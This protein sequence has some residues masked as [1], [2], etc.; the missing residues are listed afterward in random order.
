[1]ASID[2]FNN[3]AFDTVQLTAAVE[4]QD[5]LPTFVRSLNLFD[6]EPVRTTSVWVEERDGVLS[7]IPTSPRGAPLDNRTTEKRR[8]RNFETVRIAKEDKITADELQNVRAFG[9][10]TELMQVQAEVA[11]RLS[12][13]TGLLSDLALTWENHALGAI[14]GIVLDA[15]GSTVINNWFDEFGIT[16][17]TEIDFDL[18]NANPAS[19]AVRRACSQVV[20]AMAR[21]GKGAFIEGS[22][23]V[24]ALAGDDFWDDL[25]AHVE[26]RQT[27]LNTQE[28]REL[29]EGLAFEM[30]RYGGITWVNYRGTDDNSTVAINA[31]QAKFFPVGG[32]GV[33]Q[34]ALAPSETFDWVNRPGQPQYVLIVP[35]RDRNA[36]VNL[37][38]YSYPLY[39]CL[40]PEMLQRARR[41]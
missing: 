17:A 24:W 3:S 38:V 14:Q 2:V 5:F 32:R 15:D 26:V 19:G 1:M 33:F 40:R 28:A 35:D 11:R 27:F 20:R 13:P 21:A 41:T 7:L 16:Q 39:M 37:E 25:T 31:D 34:R 12:G 29:R 22:T 6:D 36:F 8:A 30:F 9:S 4:R 10:E 23:Q 18:D